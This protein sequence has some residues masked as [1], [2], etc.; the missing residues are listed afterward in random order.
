MLSLHW[1][2]RR[3][4]L[5]P[6]PRT[7]SSRLF[8][9][10]GLASGDAWAVGVTSGDQ[11][12]RGVIVRFDGAAWRTVHE[13]RN[14]G[15]DL[16]GVEALAPDDVWAV[17]A[18]PDGPLTLHWDGVS[19]RRVAAVPSGPSPADGF[20]GVAAVAPDDVWAVGSVAGFRTMLIEH[21]DGRRWSL[22]PA[23]DR[24]RG[25]SGGL[26][27]VDARSASDVWAAGA[28][29]GRSRGQPAR[30]SRA[31]KAGAGARSRCRT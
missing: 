6:T 26:V 27:R 28:S 29:T 4:A 16:F 15:S 31:G 23:P 12:G 7:P 30:S 5:V 11:G 22:V 21:W 18:A 13:E 17:G 2:G 25:G 24:G 8:D 20:L 9:V 14:P 1:D 3:W 19:W 10:S